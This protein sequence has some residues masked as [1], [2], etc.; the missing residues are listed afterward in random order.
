LGIAGENDDRIFS[1]TG[2]LVIEGQGHHACFLTEEDVDALSSVLVAYSEDDPDNDLVPTPAPPSGM[3]PYSRKKS[4]FAPL[5]TTRLLDSYAEQHARGL[6]NIFV[7]LTSTDEAGRRAIHARFKGVTRYNPIR[8]SR[9]EYTDAGMR[10]LS[11]FAVPVDWPI[12]KV[13]EGALIKGVI[14]IIN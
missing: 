11:D 5:D 14:M 7:R 4:W 3:P 1:M 2:Y 8:R 9:D 13:E 6:H 10:P 12:F